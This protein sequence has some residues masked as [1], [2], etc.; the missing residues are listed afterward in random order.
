MNK[1]CIYCE[2]SKLDFVD[3]YKYE[4]VSDSKYLGDMKI[5]KCNECDLIFSQPMPD[6][7]KLDFFYKRIYRDIQRPHYY[8]KFIKKYSYLFDINLEYVSFLTS[9]IDFNKINTIFD[10]GAG[11]GNLGYVLKKQYKHL[12][13]FCLENDINCQDTLK[14]RG[15]KNFKNLD[16]INMKFDVV[17]SLH[18]FEHLTDLKII[19][20]LINLVKQQGYLFFEVPNCNLNEGYKKRIF[21]SPHLIFFNNKNLNNFFSKTNL[22]KIFLLNT[23]YSI[24][25]D[26]ENQK[27]SKSRHDSLSIFSKI[28]KFLK[29]Y[30]PFYIQKLRLKRKLFKNFLSEDRMK[31]YFNGSKKSRC[32]RGLYKKT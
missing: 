2:S 25:H 31:W 10:F 23:S 8:S 29:K 9:N 6:I 24:Q 27:L 30:E 32:I 13:I 16:E 14:N 19:N 28:Y 18:V 17:I 15:Y 4:I 22:S 1:Q 12:E 5:Y 7:K 26:I 21:D 3:D 20:N 11:L